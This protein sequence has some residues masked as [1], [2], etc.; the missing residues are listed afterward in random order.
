MGE[1]AVRTVN[2]MVRLYGQEGLDF[3]EVA[4]R[5]RM[6]VAVVARQ[7][8]ESA[9][10]PYDPDLRRFEGDLKR[11]IREMRSG[12]HDRRQRESVPHPRRRATDHA[13]DREARY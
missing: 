9:L 4:W 11:V 3:K 2:I 6:P 10:R 7:L 12:G 1:R 5:M 8:I 13:S